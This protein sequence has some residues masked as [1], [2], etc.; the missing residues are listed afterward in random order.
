MTVRAHARVSTNLEV[1]SSYKT[2]YAQILNR[3]RNAANSFRIKARARGFEPPPPCAGSVGAT[4]SWHARITPQIPPMLASVTGT[5]PSNSTRP[6]F[7]FQFLVD[8]YV[9]PSDL[10]QGVLSL[11]RAACVMR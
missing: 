8:L 2:V 6:A 10:G 3:T 1:C 9:A 5:P 7:A 11:S 4:V